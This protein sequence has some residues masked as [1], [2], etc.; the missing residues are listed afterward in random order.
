MGY[1]LTTP[2]RNST[3]QADASTMTVIMVYPHDFNENTTH[4][5]VFATKKIQT[6]VKISPIA[7]RKKFL[8]SLQFTPYQ[9]IQ[10]DCIKIIELPRRKQL[11]FSQSIKN[12]VE[13]AKYLTM[14]DDDGV[15]E[16]C[17]EILRLHE[18]PSVAE[19][20][21]SII[22]FGTQTDF[23]VQPFILDEKHVAKVFQPT[24]AQT[25]GNQENHSD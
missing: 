14:C 23:N 22:D 1:W 20:D 5:T 24:E 15:S 17:M 3:Q 7:D 4:A 13:S 18:H 11:K 16:L 6:V 9:E 12:I 2:M 10:K 19:Q 21:L 8:S 25:D